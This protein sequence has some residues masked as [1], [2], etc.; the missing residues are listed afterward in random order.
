MK[1][2]SIVDSESSASLGGSES[3]SLLGADEIENDERPGRSNEMKA[4]DVGFVGDYNTSVV[5]VDEPRSLSEADVRKAKHHHSPI[6]N[7]APKKSNLKKSKQLKKDKHPEDLSASR[8]GQGDGD[9]GMWGYLHVCHYK[10]EYQIHLQIWFCSYIQYYDT[11]TIVLSMP[12]S[13]GKKY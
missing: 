12:V 13:T 10:N 6:P 3:E 1:D 4:I 8:G 9:D 7:T 5:P 2:L 11:T